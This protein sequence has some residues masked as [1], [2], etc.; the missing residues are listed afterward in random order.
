MLIFAYAEEC[1]LINVLDRPC[2]LSL[3][4]RLVVT[5]WMYRSVLDSLADG[6]S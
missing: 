1:Y 2:R 4:V 3:G 6:S 5:W